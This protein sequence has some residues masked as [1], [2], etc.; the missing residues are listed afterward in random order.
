MK[1]ALALVGAVLADDPTPA[2]N[3]AACTANKDCNPGDPA[4]TCCV[5]ASGAVCA[6]ATCA[7]MVDG[8]TA[9]NIS[10]CQGVTADKQDDYTMTIT[11]A[12]GNAVTLKYAKPTA[13]WTCMSGAKALAA[14]ATAALAVANMM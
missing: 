5:V 10:M 12:E 14:A 6:D 1:L 2:K 13:G 7:K 9:P 3:G 8:Q 11:V 4:T